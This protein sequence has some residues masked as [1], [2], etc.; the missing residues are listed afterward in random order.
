MTIFGDIDPAAAEDLVRQRFNDV[1]KGTVLDFSQFAAEPII[2]TSR[3]FTKETP[4]KGATIYIGYPG[5][6]LTDIKDRYAMEVLTE[7][8]GSTTSNDW[9][10][11]RLRGKQ[12]VYYAWCYN[13]AGLLD[14]YVAATCQCEAD[15]VDEVL[16][17][18]E[19]LLGRAVKGEFTEEEVTRAKSNR[20]N[21]EVLNKQTNADSATSAALDELYG[22]G[23]DWSEG[24]SDRI[25]AV[26]LEQVRN[27]ARKYFNGPPTITII[28]SGPGNDRDKK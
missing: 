28:S 26:T 19:G 3:R 5:M 27:V 17:E 4:K 2:E 12:L 18:I 1:T 15:K 10:F 6:K 16:K 11:A 13:F 25:M 24:H 9:L 21:A 7:I 23:Y 20:I 14:G 8:M 22:F